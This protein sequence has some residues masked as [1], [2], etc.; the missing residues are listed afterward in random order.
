MNGICINSERLYIIAP[1]IELLEKR[2]KEENFYEQICIN[3][4]YEKIHFPSDW[5]GEALV[6]YP[7]EI[8]RRRKN[9]DI[10]PY[11]SY[12][13]ID[14]KGKVVVG[15]ICCK[16]EPNEKNEIEIGYGINHSQKGKAYAT[17]AVLSLVSY[18]FA[19]TNVTGIRA[20]CN[21]D[22]I[23]SIRVLEKC[24]FKKNGNRFDEKDGSLIIWKREK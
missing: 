21:I 6:I 15:D 7:F 4:K 18:L 19:N 1:G 24:G 13:I 11:W 16:T 17:E 12:I 9:P 2:L 3:N 20:E 5:P 10:L 8:E 14:K 22:N 23:P